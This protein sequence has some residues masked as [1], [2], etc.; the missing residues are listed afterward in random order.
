VF[1][2]VYLAGVPVP[3]DLVQ[4][5]ARQVD[6]DL[7][8]RLLDAVTHRTAAVDLAPEEREQILIAV[9]DTEEAPLAELRSVLQADNALAIA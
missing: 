6:E 8:A 9:A 5:L 2:L 3:V 1:F 7:G 4:Q